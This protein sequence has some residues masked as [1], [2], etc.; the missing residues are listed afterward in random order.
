M[1]K[2]IERKFLVVN[3]SYRA[4]ATGIIEIAQGYISTDPD[5]TVRVRLAGNNGF[6]TIKSRNVGA[7]RNEWEYPITESAAH[8]LL[9]S[10]CRSGIIS[11]RRFIVPA[12]NG[13]KWEVDEFGGNLHGLVVAEI[14]IPSEDTEFE[15]PAFIGD[16]V[17]DDPRFFNSA[18]SAQA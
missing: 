2:E 5:C 7:V 1:S 6:I 15:K 9:D 14:E 4:L 12:E 8:A 18:L 3:D 13:L 16:E 10:S 17:T 11:K